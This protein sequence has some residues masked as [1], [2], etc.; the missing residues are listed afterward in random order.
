M[1]TQQESFTEESFGQC[2]ECGGALTVDG[3]DRLSA[4]DPNRLI[5][6]TKALP[7]QSDDGRFATRL[8]CENGH[9]WWMLTEDMRAAG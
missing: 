4:I 6:T 2:P 5:G 7:T 3:E 9:H 1:E 8:R